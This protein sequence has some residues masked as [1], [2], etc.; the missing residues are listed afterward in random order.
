MYCRFLNYLR[1]IVVHIHLFKQKAE[2]SGGLILRRCSLCS[3]AYE[4]IEKFHLLE[5]IQA[6]FEALFQIPAKLSR[7][8]DS[9]FCEHSFQ[10][11][12]NLKFVGYRADNV[13]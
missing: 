6:D 5:A 3:V 7:S 13:F 8:A 2:L 10:S 1:F 4:F 9:C 11:Y 12:V